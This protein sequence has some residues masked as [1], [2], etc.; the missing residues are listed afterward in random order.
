MN[1][2]DWNLQAAPAKLRKNPFLW[3]LPCLSSLREIQNSTMEQVLVNI[4]AQLDK[5]ATLLSLHCVIGNLQHRP[6]A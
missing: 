6:L 5:G 4:T 1:L 2:V 3:S